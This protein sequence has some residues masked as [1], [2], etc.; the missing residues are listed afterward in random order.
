[1]RTRS[2]IRN[3]LADLAS[4]FEEFAAD[5][6]TEPFGVRLMRESLDRRRDVLTEE[7]RRA[8]DSDLVMILNGQPV[9]DH[10]VEVDFLVKILSPF[11][12]A[13]SAV[14]QALEDAATKAGVIPAAI[15]DRVAVRLQA[16]FAG[17]FG[18]LLSGPPLDEQ[19]MLPIDEGDLPLPL[20]ERAIGRL[21]AIIEAGQ[22]P[23]NFDQSILDEIGD[24]GQRSASHV[25]DL[26]KSVSA[27]G[28]PVEFLWADAGHPQR[29]VV[30]SPLVATRL[31]EV[32]THIEMAEV[33]QSL[34]GR[35]V[36]ASLV[37]RTFGVEDE[38]GN[39]VR[40]TVNPDIAHRIEEYFGHPIDGR[41]LV[42]RTRSTAS[43]RH[44]DKFHLIDFAGP[45]DA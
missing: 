28:A 7:L 10:A 39:I 3:E 24:L 9:V 23:D 11:E 29:R 18:L 35:L 13:A 14:A 21:M 4:A 5:D 36:E 17:S 40:G 16:T 44:S 42:M 41:V 15:R 8:E 6:P 30:L 25:V 20:F 45:L 37:R 43:D 38:D 19:L 33:E 22:D 2:E 1:M 26:A 32:L 34:R 31:Q 27:V 12:K